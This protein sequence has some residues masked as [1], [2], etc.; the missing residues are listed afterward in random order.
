MK[1]ILA[2]LLLAVPLAAQGGVAWE[3]N[4]DAALKRAKSE[5]KLVVLDLWAEW[6]GPCQKLKRDT[7]PSAQAQAAL[8][9][10]VPVSI[11][12][13]TQ[14]RTPNPQGMEL[15]KRYQLEAY[16]TLI[17]LDA[18]G[19]ELRRHLGFMPP[20]EFAKFIEGN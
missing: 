5:H 18:S 9:K 19:K 17:V 8:R 11:M 10:V 7:F 1:K 20:S 15:A 12:V 6:C 4:L 16:P 3:E 13:E 2:A 14:D